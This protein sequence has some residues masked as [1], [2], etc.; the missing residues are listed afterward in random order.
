MK[1]FVQNT[2]LKLLFKTQFGEMTVTNGGKK[3]DLVIPSKS[4]AFSRKENENM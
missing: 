1:R 4:F 2:L 3:G